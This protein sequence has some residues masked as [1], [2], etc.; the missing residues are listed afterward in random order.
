MGLSFP[1]SGMKM[2]LLWKNSNLSAAQEAQQIKL[3]LSAYDAV[4]LVVQQRNDTPNDQ[5]AFCLPNHYTN[6]QFLDYNS[7]A[8]E[9]YRMFYM[10][11]DHITLYDGKNYAHA[12]ENNRAVLIRVYG[13]KF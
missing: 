13:V 5:A 1:G 7:G 3:G 9:S 2:D 10:A 8:V 11:A 12:T 4:F 6:V